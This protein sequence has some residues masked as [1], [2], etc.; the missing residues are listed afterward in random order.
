MCEHEA[1]DKNFTANVA[2]PTYWRVVAVRALPAFQLDV[3]FADGTRGRFDASEFIHAD[4]AG[5]FAA[6]RDVEM[7]NRVFI[8][9]G[10]VT[11]PG[12]LDLAPDAM[13]DDLKAV[14][15]NAIVKL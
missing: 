1:T 12:E 13:Y 10:A 14:A 7:F 2:T 11:W 9:H 6:L 15:P 5:V 4:D 8:D 3:E